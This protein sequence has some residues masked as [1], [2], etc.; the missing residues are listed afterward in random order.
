MKPIIDAI[1]CTVYID[2]VVELSPNVYQLNCSD[3]LWATLG[4]EIEIKTIKYFIAS[5]ETNVSMTV[6]GDSIPERGY[7]S[8]YKP[9]FYHGTINATESDLNAPVNDNLLSSDKLPM[10]WLHEP[11]DEV[12][13]HQEEEAIEI[14]SSCE[15]YFMIDANFAG[16]KNEDHFSQAV[17]PMVQLWLSMYDAIKKSKSINEDI[18]EPYKKVDLPRFGRYTGYDGKNKAVFSAYEFS[19]TS[20]KISLPFWRTNKNRC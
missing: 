2:S 4:F 15:L 12:I 20:V 5:V 19:G 11:I 18:I 1:D 13:S 17:K 8:L 14:T 7:F 10:I 9:K 16:W 3:T 6:T